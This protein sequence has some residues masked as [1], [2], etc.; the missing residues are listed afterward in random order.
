MQVYIC[1]CSDLNV[2]ALELS[3]S[4]YVGPQRSIP[5]ALIPPPGDLVAARRIAWAPTS[6]QPDGG[7]GGCETVSSL[8]NSDAFKPFSGV[9]HRHI[10]GRRVARHSERSFS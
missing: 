8:I 2:D 3:T 9:R 4:L 7:L 6:R 10:G 5:V 1:R